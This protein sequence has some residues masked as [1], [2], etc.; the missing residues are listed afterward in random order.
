MPV[1]EGM[2][3][4]FEAGESTLGEFVSQYAWFG[5]DASPP[6]HATYVRIGRRPDGR[7]VC[8]GL[9]VGGLSFDYGPDMPEITARALR[10]IKLP[11]LVEQAVMSGTGDWEERV[12]RLLDASLPVRPRVRRRQLGDDHFRDVAESYRQAMV[13]APQAPTQWLAKQWHV[14]EPTLRRWL[15]RAR[16]KG[17]L[18][19]SMPGK[20]GEAPKKRGRK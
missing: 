9:I 5:C 18:G 4:W 11:H 2:I 8:T 15:Q 14:S 7:L 6:E 20:A 16:D 19:A 1:P 12:R 17:Y 3:Y 13:K 10:E